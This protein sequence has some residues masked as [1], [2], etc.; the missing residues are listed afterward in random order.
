MLRGVGEGFAI[1]MP[2]S[3]KT[4]A[5]ED[6]A[7]AQALGIFDQHIGAAVLAPK[8]LAETILH[9][10]NPGAGG[11][12][13]QHVNDG[14]VNVRDSDSR[15]TPPDVLRTKYLLFFET[16]QGE[17]GILTRDGLLPDGSGGENDNVAEYLFGEVPVFSCGTPADIGGAE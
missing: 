6:R 17:D 5:L 1:R 13:V 14:A 4:Q 9:M 16:L 15:L 2:L 8:I 11:G 3:E 12:V 7:I 10:L